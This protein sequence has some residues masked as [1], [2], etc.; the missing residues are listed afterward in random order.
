MG[1]QTSDVLKQLQTLAD[2]KTLTPVVLIHLGTNGYISETQLRKILALLADRKRVIL[3]NTHVPRRWMEANNALIDRVIG[4]YPNVV[5]VNW[6]DLSDGQ[7]DY[8]IS[9]GV[10]LTDIG[11]RAFIG[12]IMRTGHLAREPSAAGRNVVDP[13]RPYDYGAGDFSATLVRR[14]QPAAPDSYWK[15]M[16]QCETGG[17][18]QNGG[19]YSGGLGIFAEAWAAW[20]GLEFAPTPA[21]ATPAQQIEIAN[22]I[23]T[24]GWKKADGTTVAPEGFT[25]WRCLTA[26]G[27]PPAETGYTFTAASVLAQQ[28]HLKERGDV[29]RDLELMLGLPPDGIYGKRVRLR[30]IALLTAR[31]LPVDLA[32]SA[33]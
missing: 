26:V 16:A 6:R 19:R 2:A 18:W 25:R 17:N 23:S 7:P 1:W 15:R 14:P 9:D 29:V 20:G 24:Q 22:R 28:F 12:E 10:H 3:V 27:R 30:H 32:G 31:R 11:Q 5:L 4:D 13:D 33:P 8:F 21:L